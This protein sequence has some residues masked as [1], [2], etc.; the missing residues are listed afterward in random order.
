MPLDFEIGL[1][2][3][4]LNDSGAKVRPMAEKEVIGS[5]Y[6]VHTNTFIFGGPPRFQTQVTNG[7]QEKLTATATPESDIGRD[8]LGVLK[9]LTGPLS[10]LHFRRHNSLVNHS[11]NG[12]VHFPQLTM[13]V[14]WAKNEISADPNLSSV[15]T[16]GSFS[17]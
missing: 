7:Q 2:L 15:T 9:K 11:T 10:R 12:R 16:T 5:K 1:T 3:T 8:Y 17:Q 6:Q 14:K 4:A 13:P